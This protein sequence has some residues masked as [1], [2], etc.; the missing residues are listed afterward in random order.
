MFAK[1]TLAALAL[2]FAGL[3]AAAA[4]TVTKQ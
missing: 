3:S 1:T 4:S 2:S